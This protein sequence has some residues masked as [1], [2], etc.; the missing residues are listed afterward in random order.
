MLNFDDKTPSPLL[1]IDTIEYMKEW[2]EKWF[3]ENGLSNILNDFDISK[4]VVQGVNLHRLGTPPSELNENFLKN[5]VKYS[6]PTLKLVF[7]DEEHQNQINLLEEYSTIIIEEEN[8]EED[9]VVIKKTTPH[10][11]SKL[12]QAREIYKTNKHLSRKELVN[13]FIDELKM[14][15]KSASTYYY[16]VQS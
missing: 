12:A 1:Y 10:A 14:N 3:P 4:Y 6:L 13:L 7:D 15:P 9:E 5:A 11:H 16:L 2:L 8:V